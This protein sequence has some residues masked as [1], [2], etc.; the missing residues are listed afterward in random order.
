MKKSF[1][2][3]V[4]LLAALI[5]SGCDDI[6][7]GIVDKQPVQ[8]NSYIRTAPDNFVFNSADSSFV[9]SVY[10]DK[11]EDFSATLLVLDPDGKRLFPSPIVLEDNGADGDTVKGDG[12]YSARLKF[13][14]S[15]PNGKY[16]F[17]Y[18][19]TAEGVQKKSFIHYLNYFNGQ[20]NYPPVI[21]ELSMPDTI[22][23]GVPLIIVLKVFDANGLDDI[24][25]VSFIF[26]KPDGS[27]SDP[28]NMRNDGNTDL[29]GDQVAGDDLYSY[30][31]PFP[32]S[33]KGQY[34]KFE[35]FAEDRNGLRSNIIIHNLFIK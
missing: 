28:V 15:Y 4:P 21:S 1:I 5:S 19:L 26:Y 8:F 33:A 23:A 14:K 34:R 16:T 32:E 35:F 9:T 3:Y 31:N 2:L 20:Q 29:D 22:A 7:S 12:I 6:P 24:K 11:K 30:K 10:S 27:A 18:Y 25:R 17:E 13:S